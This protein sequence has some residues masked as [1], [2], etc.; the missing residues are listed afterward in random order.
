MDALHHPFRRTG[1]VVVSVICVVLLATVAT[2][3]V[4]ADVTR[5]LDSGETFCSG[6]TLEFEVDADYELYRVTEPE[7][8]QPVDPEHVR[9]ID[10]DDGR[11]AVDTGGL[12]PDR[13]M[14]VEASRADDGIVTNDGAILRDGEVVGSGSAPSA[15]WYVESCPSTSQLQGGSQ[16]IRFDESARWTLDVDFPADDQLYL[17]A[18]GVGNETLASF[19]EGATV[20]SEPN[21]D[22]DDWVRVDVP[23][24]GQIPV[25]IPFQAACGPAGGAFRLTVAGVDTGATTTARSFVRVDEDRAYRFEQRSYYGRQGDALEIPVGVRGCRDDVTIRVTQQDPAF[26]LQVDLEDSTSNGVVTLLVDTGTL[27]DDPDGAVSARGSDRVTRVKL[28]TDV[29][30]DTLPYGNY[31]VR[32]DADRRD[33]D[34][35]GLILDRAETTA[36]TTTTSTTT[37]PT[38]VTSTTT[39]SA[40]TPTTAPPT[41]ET[42]TT[43]TSAFGP[44]FGFLATLLALFGTALLVAHRRR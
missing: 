32:L 6:Q 40:T 29:E 30:G 13:Y 7:E 28:N 31:A 14:V 17:R 35:V 25:E 43:T 27:L 36:T 37:T 16:T 19:V 42:T 33:V 18:E 24:D 11:L 41:T 23:D 2:T 3:S 44:G 4:A 8:G 39:T 9:D 15:G 34:S 20:V 22:V 21:S 26:S 5:D 12:A 38:S 10:V 1:T